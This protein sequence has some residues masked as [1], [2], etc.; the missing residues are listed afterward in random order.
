MLDTTPRPAG[1]RKWVLLALASVLVLVGS[2]LTGGYFL[3]R[4]EPIALAVGD[5][6]SLD[7]TG[8][9]EYGCADGKALYRI[10]ARESVVW[11]LES[12][13]M[14]YPD[15]TKAVGDVPSANPGVVLCLTPT[16]FNTSDPGALQAGD[17]IEVTGAGDTVNRIPC[18]VNKETKVLSTELHRQV[19]VTDQACRDQPQARQAFAQ[20]SLGGRAI[21][22]C[23]FITDPQ[24]IDSAQVNDCTNQDLRKIVRCD[25]REANYRV[26]TVR[27]LHQR[28]AKPQ[29][30]EVFGANA[31]SMTHNEKTD[32]VLTICLGP[33]DDNAVLY[34]K[35]GDCVVSGGTG[36]ADRSRRADCADP[37]T[38]HKVIDRHES[39]D[40]NCPATSPAWITFDPGV[41]NGLTICLARK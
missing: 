32:L 7:V 23:T 5:C 37:A 41:T 38:T 3:L 21:V 39:N 29:C 34:S 4:P 19:P 24:N 30:P 1:R 28:P 33:S 11:P 9:V 20:P 8:P 40:G 14:K 36:P 16:R 2:L 18:A 35:V 27:A 26:L 6:V 10:T 13:C 15:V 25:S 12:A 31:F 17:C 22:L